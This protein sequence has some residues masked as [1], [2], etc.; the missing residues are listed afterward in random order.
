MLTWL[1]KYYHCNLYTKV[2]RIW[3]ML[4]L[5]HFIL[6]TSE[7]ILAIIIAYLIICFYVIWLHSLNS[8]HEIYTN[9]RC[10]CNT[11]TETLLA[12]AACLKTIPASILS[13]L[14][15]ALCELYN[16]IMRP[17]K[18]SRYS[19]Y[20]AYHSKATW[21]VHEKERALTATIKLSSTA[22]APPQDHDMCALI[23]LDAI[24]KFTYTQSIVLSE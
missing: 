10:D 23:T 7:L 13:T 20:K 22:A 9:L 1:K 4:W 11:T 24:N 6:L 19:Y 8:N 15:S 12:H 3:I 18:S 2:L 16:V 17:R 5:Q 14:M 21:F